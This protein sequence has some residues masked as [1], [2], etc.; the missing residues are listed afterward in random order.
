MSCA[1]LSVVA[2]AGRFSS[3]RTGSDRSL[4]AFCRFPGNES[5]R[6][7]FVPE[8]GRCAGCDYF[9]WEQPQF[10]HF[11]R[12]RRRRTSGE[13]SPCQRQNDHGETPPLPPVGRGD[14]LKRHARKITRCA[15][16]AAPGLVAL[17]I[18]VYS[19]ALPSAVRRQW[20]GR[21]AN[22]QGFG[23]LDVEPASKGLDSRW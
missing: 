22:P 4:R 9:F 6:Q 1:A 18:V 8:W 21:R 12:V 11:D 13:I 5:P 19:M 15:S 3:S 16:G 14:K 23:N 17:A 10:C 20:D 7:T 2:G